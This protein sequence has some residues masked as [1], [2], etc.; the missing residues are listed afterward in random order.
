MA[1][2]DRA[3]NTV[4]RQLGHSRRDSASIFQISR[5]VAAGLVLLLSFGFIFYLSNANQEKQTLSTFN[6]EAL[7]DV[8]VNANLQP[9][10]I[11]RIYETLYPKSSD[12]KVP[13]AHRND[14][15]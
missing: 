4:E 13:S 7:Q 15:M 8:D 6:I 11:N 5:L 1:P 14:S 12:T 3:W 2:S 9:E 10:D